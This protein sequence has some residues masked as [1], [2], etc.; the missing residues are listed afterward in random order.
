MSNEIRLVFIIFWTSSFE[1]IN[2]TS[3]AVSDKAVQCDFSF[4]VSRD[5]I[6]NQTTVIGHVGQDSIMTFTSPGMFEIITD[7]LLVHQ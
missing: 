6:L 7:T 4:S 2:G 1:V 5:H 3:T